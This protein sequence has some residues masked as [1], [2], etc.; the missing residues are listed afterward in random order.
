LAELDLN[1][2]RQFEG[3]NPTTLSKRSGEREPITY[4]EGMI[5]DGRNR[6][7]A[8]VEAGMG[9]RRAASG[10]D[11][12]HARGARL[13]R[14]RRSPSARHRLRHGRRG[15]ARREDRRDDP[16]RYA[17]ADHYPF[18]ITAA[19]HNESA[20]Q[21]LEFLKSPAAREIVKARAYG[22]IPP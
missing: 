13:R 4:Y 19:S 22:V 11:R 14:A 17:P 1:R 9:R 5:L 2:K 15:G 8:C 20:A 16:R 6:Y 12:Q 3:N 10:D 18:A 21:F 7:R